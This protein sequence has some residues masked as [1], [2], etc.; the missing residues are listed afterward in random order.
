[1]RSIIVDHRIRVV[2]D[3][4]ISVYLSVCFRPVNKR[5][6]LNCRQLSQE[7]V[8]GNTLNENVDQKKTEVG[9]LLVWGSPFVGSPE[10][11]ARNQDLDG[12]ISG[13]N[14]AER[15]ILVTSKDNHQALPRTT[16]L[17]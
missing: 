17:V 4:V 1:M 14:A 11:F 9:S 6:R 2:E 5:G 13:E 12:T 15:L 7:A 16:S 8:A 3:V 10:N